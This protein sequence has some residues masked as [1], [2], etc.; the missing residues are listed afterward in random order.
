MTAVCKCA[1]TFV[2][3]KPVNILTTG[4]FPTCL[5]ARKLGVFDEVAASAAAFCAD[6]PGV[7]CLYVCVVVVRGWRGQLA[8]AGGSMKE[9]VAVSYYSPPAHSML[10]QLRLGGD[11]SIKLCHLLVLPLSFRQCSSVIVL[12]MHLCS[13]YSSLHHSGYFNMCVCVAGGGERTASRTFPH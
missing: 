10:R 13:P 6:K 2:S 4:Q 8:A 9:W 1:S 11:T 7:L 3:V 5:M 12:G